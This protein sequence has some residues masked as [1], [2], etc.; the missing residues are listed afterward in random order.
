M[1][2]LWGYKIGELFFNNLFEGGLD[3]KKDW[4]SHYYAQDPH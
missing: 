3:N 1:F 2:I 4:N